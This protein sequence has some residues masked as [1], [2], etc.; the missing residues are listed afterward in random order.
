MAAD[1]ARPW[2]D[3]M[4]DAIVWIER[5]T[6][7]IWRASIVRKFGSGTRLG[8]PGHVSPLQQVGHPRYWLRPETRRPQ[9]CLS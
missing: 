6:G 1:H 8:V 9:A 3:D 7:S 2:L 5:I 4:L